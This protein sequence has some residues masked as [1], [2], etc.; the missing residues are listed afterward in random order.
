MRMSI[1]RLACLCI[2]TLGMA[3]SQAAAADVVPFR[4]YWAGTTVSA[5]PVAPN[6]VLVVASGSGN[7][8]QLG[9]F[10]MTSPHLTY[11]DTFAV[12]GEHV[13]TAA[14]GDT[15]IAH[16][17]GQFVQN[18]DGDLEATFDCV[19]TAGTGRFEGATGS[20]DFH[21]VAVANGTTGFDSAA[22][23]DGVIST[24]GSNK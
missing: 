14:N 5:T 12:E 15:L 24:A 7:A 10:V 18:A 13:F 2:L 6:V 17:T 9:R 11:L 3:V 21:I 4:G 20:Y 23:I 16:F 19:I 1:R 8:T 22:T